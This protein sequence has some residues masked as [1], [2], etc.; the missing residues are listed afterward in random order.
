MSS[1]FKT[2]KPGTS[3]K[4]GNSARIL[5]ANAVRAVLRDKTPL[6][7]A[8]SAQALFWQMEPRDRAFARLIAASVFRRRG[9]IDRVLK[10]YIKKNTPDFTMAVLRCG[11]AQILFLQTPAHAAVNGAVA[12]LRRSRKTA[13]MAGLANAVLRRI[14]EAGQAALKHSSTL[15]NL[16]KWLR[17][18][19]YKTYGGKALQAMA[20]QLAKEPPLDLTLK[21]GADY[22]KGLVLPGGTI[23]LDKVGNVRALPGYKEG[24]WW[25]QDVSA[26]LPVRLLGDVTGQRVLD[27]CAA[28]GGKTLQLASAGARVT[29][30][31]K[32]ESRLGRLKDNL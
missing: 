2:T 18:E 28:P 16:P 6:D 17:A 14:S 31:D 13:H 29:A 26:A 30:L 19:W 32:H 22:P 12:T 5:A 8:L 20:D 27:M 7:Q 1:K 4:P 24:D 11:V 23:R 15:D 21:P 9:Q 25:V 3:K 10:P